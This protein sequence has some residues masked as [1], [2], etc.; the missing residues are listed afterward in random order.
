MDRR[1]LARRDLHNAIRTCAVMERSPMNPRPRLKLLLF[2]FLCLLAVPGLT[3]AQV[4]E[5]SLAGTV[6]DTT[7]AAV[8]DAQ[9]SVTNVATQESREVTTDADGIY[10]A[11]YLAPG[12]YS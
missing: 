9:I 3:C 7:G 8:A 11:S 10:R 12:K 5:G 4:T 6:T 2:A 1:S